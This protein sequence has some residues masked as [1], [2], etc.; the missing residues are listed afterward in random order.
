M[1]VPSRTLS[2]SQLVLEADPGWR[3]ASN[4]P[5]AFEFSNG[6][7]FYDPVPLYGSGKITDDF[8][9]QIVDDDGNAIQS[10]T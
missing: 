7:R 10:D 3:R 8:G 5:W 1:A 6:R 2:W 4:Q 9:T